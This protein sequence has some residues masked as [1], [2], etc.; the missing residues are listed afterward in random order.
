MT[1]TFVLGKK[2]NR[3]LAIINQSGNFR[4]MDDSVEFSL[5]YHDVNY[6][7]EVNVVVY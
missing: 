4:Y 2:N 1:Y 6:K 3:L 7:C 5:D